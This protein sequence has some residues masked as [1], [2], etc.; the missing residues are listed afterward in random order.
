MEIDKERKRIRGC[1]ANGE[2]PLEDPE[3]AASARKKRD[4]IGSGTYGAAQQGTMCKTGACND[5]LLVQAKTTQALR[6]EETTSPNP[7]ALQALCLQTLRCSCLQ[8]E[9][10]PSLV[11]QL[12]PCPKKEPCVCQRHC[13]QTPHRKSDKEVEIGI[14]FQL[15]FVMLVQHVWTCS[16]N[17]VSQCQSS[18]I[19]CSVLAS[20]L[21]CQWSP[22][23]W[24][25]QL[26]SPRISLAHGLDYQMHSG[27]PLKGIGSSA[28]IRCQNPDDYHWKHC[29]HLYEQSL[30]SAPISCLRMDQC[31]EEDGKISAT[32]NLDWWP[33]RRDTSLRMHGNATFAPKKADRMASSFGDDCFVTTRSVRHAP[34]YRSAWTCEFGF[35]VNIQAHQKCLTNSSG[36]MHTVPGLLVQLVQLSTGRSYEKLRVSRRFP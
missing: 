29:A 31:R 12:S 6:V 4:Q 36:G 33:T 7:N 11:D 2:D 3:T 15:P 24:T 28:F 16:C 5:T 30:S 9:T 1:I 26:Q 13:E 8:L 32:I 21:K 10:S 20:V 25:Q 18:S 22:L 35:L 27:F 17:F 19:S 34:W 23:M 14:H